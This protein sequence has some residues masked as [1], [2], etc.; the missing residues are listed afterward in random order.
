MEMAEKMPA[1]SAWNGRKAAPSKGGSRAAWMDLIRTGGRDGGTQAEVSL[2]ALKLVTTSEGNGGG[3]G[4]V[5]LDVIATR[6]GAA[7]R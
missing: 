4:H 6:A 7:L 2:A 5:L 3:R 1:S